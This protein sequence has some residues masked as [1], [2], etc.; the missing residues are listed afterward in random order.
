MGVVC[1]T[2]WRWFVVGCQLCYI[3]SVFYGCLASFGY[4]DVCCTCGAC[5]DR[6]CAQSDEG[7]MWLGLCPVGGDLCGVHVRLCC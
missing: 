6:L 1:L 4:V 3:C 7:A 5:W 2:G